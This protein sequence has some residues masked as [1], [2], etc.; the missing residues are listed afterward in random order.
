[1][2]GGE[3]ETGEEGGRGRERGRGKMKRRGREGF[4]G[5][6]CRRKDMERKAA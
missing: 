2:W 1:V 3:R 6:V 4:V 5:R